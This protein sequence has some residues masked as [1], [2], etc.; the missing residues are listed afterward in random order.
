MG[1]FIDNLITSKESQGVR[2]VLEALNH[3]ED[4]RQ[5]SLVVACP[6]LLTIQ[7][8][9]RHGSVDIKHDVYARSI[10]D[11]NAF[12][13]VQGRIDIIDADCVDLGEHL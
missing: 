9:R 4:A 13:V 10:E 3:T 7:T 12:I 8:I 11:G 5:I 6:G 2:I 1:G